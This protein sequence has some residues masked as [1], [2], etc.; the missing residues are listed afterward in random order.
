MGPTT[1]YFLDHYVSESGVRRDSDKVSALYKMPMPKD[2]KDL[3]SLLGGL[4]CN[5]KF[6]TK[7]ANRIQRLPLLTL[8]QSLYGNVAT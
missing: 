4:F 7:A 5:G 1:V 8:Y 6:L 3:R 2:M